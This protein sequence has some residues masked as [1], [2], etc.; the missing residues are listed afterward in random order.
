MSPLLHSTM[1]QITLT[2]YIQ[3]FPWLAFILCKICTTLSCSQF[4]PTFLSEE[5]VFLYHLLSRL[6]TVKMKMESPMKI[7]NGIVSPPI[8][9]SAARV[10]SEWKLELFLFCYCCH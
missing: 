6:T 8:K 3:S 10:V 5:E 2:S 9:V 1:N 4:V 7:K